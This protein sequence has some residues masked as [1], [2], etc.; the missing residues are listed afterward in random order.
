MCLSI[1]LTFAPHP[2]ILTFA[3]HPHSVILLAYQIGAHEPTLVSSSLL[4]SFIE[5]HMNMLYVFKMKVFC[6]LIAD[7]ATVICP[8][9]L[10]LV[11]STT[12]LAPR[13]PVFYKRILFL[14][15]YYSEMVR[16]V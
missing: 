14:F 9:S 4:L 12:P 10:K 6:M 16:H 2:K 1:I 13:V 5:M 3:P 7:C 15:F 8:E 11:L